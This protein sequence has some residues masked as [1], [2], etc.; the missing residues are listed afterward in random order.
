[1]WFCVDCIGL[2]TSQSAEN[3][4]K[5]IYPERKTWTNLKRY[6]AS[7]HLAWTDGNTRVGD[8]EHW[9]KNPLLDLVIGSERDAHQK[10]R[11]I[12]SSVSPGD[13]DLATELPKVLT[14]RDSPGRD[15]QVR[16]RE[17]WS[18]A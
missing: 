16:Q 10:L 14:V 8:P 6:H 9:T 15:D 11:D 5:Q 7:L 17:F 12:R 2:W 3:V 18:L 1:M 4:M 13:T